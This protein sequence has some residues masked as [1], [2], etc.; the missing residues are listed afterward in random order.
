MISQWKWKDPSKK[1]NF[2]PQSKRVKYPIT[3]NY[4]VDIL[5][6]VL[7]FNVAKIF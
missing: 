4:G 6:S 1:L 5:F 2:L 7:V 3:V